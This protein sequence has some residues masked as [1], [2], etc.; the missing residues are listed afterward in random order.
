MNI[1]QIQEEIQIISANSNLTKEE[2]ISRIKVYQTFIESSIQETKYNEQMLQFIEGAIELGN[3]SNQ[4]Y[5]IEDSLDVNKVSLKGN[6][7]ESDLVKDLNKKGIENFTLSDLRILYSPS[8]E[9]ENG[10]NLTETNL[11]MNLY[12]QIENIEQIEQM[13]MEIIS[14]NLG[15]LLGKDIISKTNESGIIQSDGKA[16]IQLTDKS[17]EQL[18]SNYKKAIV[19][20]DQLYANE[21]VL[22][23]KT[24]QVTTQMLSQLFTYYM[25][26]NKKVPMNVVEQLQVQNQQTYEEQGKTL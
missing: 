25:N 19:K 22:D 26:G 1:E 5:Q 7:L 3:V 24:K 18:Q 17:N 8:Y 4:S 13:Q 9:Q 16:V 23:L 12:G 6:I 15:D 21:G 10:V 14:R 2:K 11:A 20:I